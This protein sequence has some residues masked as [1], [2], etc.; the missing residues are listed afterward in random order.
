MSAIR[1]VRAVIGLPFVVVGIALV[2]FGAIVGGIG[3]WNIER[4]DG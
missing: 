4:L 2:I 1:T 3:A